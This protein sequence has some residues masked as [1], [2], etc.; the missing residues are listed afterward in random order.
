MM[1]MSKESLKIFVFRLCRF[2]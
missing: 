1:T 2:E